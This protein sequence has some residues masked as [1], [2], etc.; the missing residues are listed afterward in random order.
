LVLIPQ[1]MAYAELAGLPPHHGLFAAGLPP[2]V[3]AVFASSPFLQTGPTALT[4]LLTVGALST[5]AVPFGPEYV[6]LAALLALVVGVVRVTVGRLRAGSIAYLMGMPVLRGFTAAAAVLIVSSQVPA[7]LGVSIDGD[8][9]LTR[10]ALAI[11]H[12]EDW[13]VVAIGLSAAALVILVGGKKLHPLFPGVLLVVILGIVYGSRADDAGRLVGEVPDVL[14]P[15]LTLDLPWSRLPALLISGGVIALVGFA[16]AASVAQAYAERTRTE[17]DPDAEFV[18]QGAA[19]L[20]SGLFAGFPVGASFGRSALNRHA[21]AVT[22]LSGAVTGLVALLFLP[23]AFILAPLPVAVLGAV[24]VGAISKFLDPRPLFEL[25]RK[26]R[27]QAGIAYATFV[28]TLVLSPHIEYA[29]LGGIALALGVHIWRETVVE[30]WSEIV[31]TTL[32]LQPRGVIWFGTATSFR[33]HMAKLIAEHPEVDALTMDLTRLGRVDLTGAFMLR[34]LAE[35]AMEAG[36]HVAFI[37]GPARTA[38]LLARVCGHI[39][40]ERSIGPPD[41]SRDD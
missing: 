31:G 14:F 8:T 37:G 32:H 7:I 41:D 27:P 1:S 26:S 36:L 5:L 22:R 12:P 35:S 39:P 6:A 16:E 38:T 40:H 24:V 21:G 9:I 4:S 25:H 17:W 15:P 29:V 30:V 19:N 11:A 28:L 33:Q 23:F 10:A 2:L 13:N 18:S 34:D 3:A 20:V